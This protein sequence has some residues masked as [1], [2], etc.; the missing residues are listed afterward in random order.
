M[1]KNKSMATR[2]VSHAQSAK[3]AAMV[4]T[5][6]VPLGGFQFH[7]ETQHKGAWTGKKDK[8]RASKTQRK[9]KSVLICLRI[10]DG[11]Q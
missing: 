4:R 7:T 10:P 5:Q 1:N 6:P 3:L 2:A 8:L 11:S 9:A